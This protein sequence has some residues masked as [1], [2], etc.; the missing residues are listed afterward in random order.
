MAAVITAMETSWIGPFTGLSPRCFGKLV[1]VVR[2]ELLDEARCGRPWSL[3]L[4]DR[5]LLVTAYWRTNLTMRQLAPLFG[6]SKSAADRI[7]DHLGPKLALQPRKRFRKDTVLIVDGTLVPTRDHPVAERSKN[8]RYSTAHQVVIDADTCL[9]VVVGQPLPGNRHDSRGWE[10]SGAK[11]AVGTTMTNCRRRLPGHRPGHP[12]PPPQGRRTPI[13]EGRT[14]PVPQ[15]GPGPRRAHL[16][17][18]EELED[19][20]RL[21]P[22]RRRRSPRHARHR[23]S[24]QPRP[25]RISERA[26]RRSTASPPTRRSLRDSP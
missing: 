22:Q 23:P 13:L 5:I 16:R 17:P 2:R 26:T 21:P 10:E 8:Y 20:A 15:A 12:A 4:E 6:I 24:A 7:T 14:Q 1:T 19:P 18:H 3:P 25:R 11:A 9:V